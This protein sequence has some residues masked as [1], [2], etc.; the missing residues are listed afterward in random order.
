MILWIS[1]G[2]VTQKVR[3]VMARQLLSTGCHD[4]RIL[5]LPIGN[6]LPGLLERKAP[7]GGMTAKAMDKAK[8]INADLDAK[9]CLIISEIAQRVKADVIVS[10]CFQ[11]TNAIS[12]EFV[13]EW[14]ACGSLY[15]LHG[16]EKTFP[17]IGMINPCSI[18][19]GGNAAY[20]ANAT[21]AKIAR[22]ANHKQRACPSF[23]FTFCN[24]VESVAE[25]A[26][27]AEK[28]VMI[29]EDIETSQHRIDCSGFTLLRQ[30]GSLKTYC[31]PHQDKRRPDQQYRFFS[32]PDE[33]EIHRL[34]CQVQNTTAPKIYQNGLYDC[35]YQVRD[36]LP[37]RNYLLDTM[38]MQ[39]ALYSEAPKK[40]WQI[41]MAY[42]DYMT[43]W[44]DDIKGEKEEGREISD[45]TYMRFWQYNGLD[46]YYTML[47]AIRL[48]E[49]F[50]KQPYAYA[51]YN[52][53]FRLAIGPFFEASMGGLRINHDRW[54]E[55]IDAKSKE[56]E[57]ARI[58]LQR[59]VGPDF[60]PASSAQVGYFLYDFLG[61][62][63]TRLQKRH[64]KQYGAKCTD[65]KV[66]KLVREQNNPFIDNFLDRLASYTKPA[67]I[68]SVFAPWDKFTY[69]GQGWALEWLN[70]CGTET[71]RASSTHSQ[72]W[73][74]G[75]GQNITAKLREWFEA[76]KD[77]VMFSGDYS[78]S[79]D[80]WVAYD[81]E[82]PVKIDLV[83]S[84]KDPHCFHAS[85]FFGYPYEELKKAHDNEE[86]WVDNSETGIRS[87]TKKIGHGKNY[88]AQKD[89]IYDL[90]GR[91]G[92]VHAAIALGYKDAANWPTEKLVEVCDFL[93]KRY[94]DPKI[95]MYKRLIPWR[96]EL[97]A[98][99]VEHHGL[100]TNPFGFTRH[101]LGDLRDSG[102]HR[103]IAA[104]VGQGDTAG[105]VNR[106][107]LKI[108][109]GGVCDANC[110]FRKQVH[111]ELVFLIHKSV[112]REKVSQI[113]SIME[114]PTMLHGHM[115]KI[116]VDPK[117]GLI[118]GKH[119]LSW[120]PDVSYDD[121]VKF[122]QDRFGYVPGFSA[123]EQLETSTAAPLEFSS[124]LSS[125]Q[126]DLE[127]EDDDD[128]PEQGVELAQL[129]ASM[130]AE[131]E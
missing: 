95:G 106:A 3:S 109:Y 91:K 1:A 26:R 117:V 34:L 52:T 57:E 53:T 8:R 104:Q 118:W 116:P 27:E 44:K 21:Y 16:K 124:L 68:L 74:G 70:S 77:W 58:S 92:V 59:L 114:E 39:H 82:D 86:D 14:N 23:N 48:L 56:A 112:I 88:D 55:T 94:D 62:K 72:F 122:T 51:N 90:M 36:G 50:K 81:A 47:I 43:F 17:V 64:P 32:Q 113:V 75:N 45:E 102:T 67:K 9:A 79:D 107:L 18:F 80:R 119:M 69:R 35:A 131:G 111:D 6:Y 20:L 115:V 33:R 41:A 128:E 11:V 5:V 42:L 127:V 46:T 85:M 29:A 84:G 71:G 4:Y 89:T 73:C 130:E 120:K 108:Y 22:W 30:D 12:G 15:W 31:V 78:A 63:Q 97:V 61:A 93:C 110:F 2:T 129:E 40:L 66:L 60:N 125:M 25:L 87:L 65:A 121:V 99:V 100:M 103:E 83:E 37:P 98:S 105:N 28:A 19:R 7:R 101:F 24:S 38:V 10:Q 76:P 96:R 49:E 126:L 13:T 123:S 54:K